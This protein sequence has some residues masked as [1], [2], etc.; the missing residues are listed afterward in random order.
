MAKG[1]K[2]GGGSRKGKPNKL[3]TDLRSMVLNSLAKVGGEDYLIK[4]SRINAAAYM[5]LVGK[6]LPKEI[7]GADGAPLFPGR[8]EVVPVAPK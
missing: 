4:Q 7:T 1:T 5:T 2:T 6:C 3:T 8:I